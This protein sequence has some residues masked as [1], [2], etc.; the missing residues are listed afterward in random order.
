MFSFAACMF[1]IF[2]GFFMSMTL[3]FCISIYLIGFTPAFIDKWLQLWP[4]AY[5]IAVLSIIVYRP[6]ALYLAGKVIKWRQSR[7]HQ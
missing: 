5:P 2:M 6:L 7:H 3:T 1:A 4:I